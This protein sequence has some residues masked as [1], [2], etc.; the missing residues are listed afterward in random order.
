MADNHQLVLHPWAEVLA[1]KKELVVKS[2][3][4]DDTQHKVSSLHDI[5]E[6][7]WQEHYPLAQGLMG[8]IQHTIKPQPGPML[9]STCHAIT[10]AMVTPLGYT[11]QVDHNGGGSTL[12]SQH[13]NK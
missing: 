11:W 2:H 9:P 3:Q 13:P 1:L 8:L 5:V 10:P 12:P 6:A 4:L 7:L